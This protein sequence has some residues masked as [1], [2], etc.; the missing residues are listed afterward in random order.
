MQR[1]VI[2]GPILEEYDENHF[3]AGLL[4]E[5]MVGVGGTEIPAVK[6]H[7]WWGQSGVMLQ[8]GAHVCWWEENKVGVVRTYH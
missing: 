6:G 8:G 7:G 4:G 2:K 1:E 5:G 3:E